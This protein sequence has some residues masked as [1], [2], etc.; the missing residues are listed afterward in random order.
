MTNDTDFQALNEYFC[1][2]SQIKQE[3]YAVTLNAFNELKKEASEVIDALRTN[4][5]PGRY[6]LD[7][8]YS[9]A[10]AYEAEIRFSGDALS[11]QMHS[12]V[13]AFPDEHAIHKSAEVKDD[14]NAGFVGMIS[15]YNFLA[16]SLRFNRLADSGY[17]LG[18]LFVNKRGNYFMDGNRQFSFLFKDFSVQNFDQTV[19]KKIVQTAMK[20]SI[21]FDLYVPPFDAVKEITLHQKIVQQGTTAVKTG[22]RMG[23]DYEGRTD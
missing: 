19:A 1:D 3:V 4:K 23:F 21:D 8:A 17:L 20:H 15:I 22:K 10:G 2:K 18:R 6:D 7:L 16:D 12:N 9:E 11:F 14:N 5:K 13:F